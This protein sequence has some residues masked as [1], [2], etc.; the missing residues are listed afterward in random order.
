MHARADA[1]APWEVDDA[2]LLAA[3]PLVGLVHAT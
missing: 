2:G 1:D 3:N